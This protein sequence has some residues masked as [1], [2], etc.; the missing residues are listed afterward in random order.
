MSKSGTIKAALDRVNDVRMAFGVD[1]L[2]KMPKGLVSQSNDCPVH[3]A[4]GFREN[5][6]YGD[7]VSVYSRDV[8]R[9]MAKVWDTRVHD[10]RNRKDSYILENYYREEHGRW[11]VE[12]PPEIRKFV[13]KFD[14]GKFKSLHPANTEE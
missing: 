2:D 10:V 14:S 1:P 4:L 12:T 7:T 9:T 3:N 8:A 6:V 5:N 13:N 11:V